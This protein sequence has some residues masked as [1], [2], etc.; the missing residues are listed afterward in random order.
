M[1][2][3]APSVKIL[4]ISALVK[5]IGISRST[6]YDWLNPKSPRYDATFPKQ[7]R[8]GMQSVGWMESE[9]DKWLEECCP[10]V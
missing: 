3:I 4:R 10:Q 9:I 5:K 8:L 6:I 1:T 7:R 2:C